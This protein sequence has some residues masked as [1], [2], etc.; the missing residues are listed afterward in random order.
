MGTQQDTQH[1]SE[2]MFSIKQIHQFVPE[3]NSV[4]DILMEEDF[5]HGKP[6][7]LVAITPHLKHKWAG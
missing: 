4:Y 7:I 6:V 2:V 1:N 5:N 3:Y